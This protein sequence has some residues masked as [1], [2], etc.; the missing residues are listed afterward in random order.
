V[1]RIAQYKGLFQGILK[2]GVS[3]DSEQK[4][5]FV[6]G[7][8]ERAELFLEQILQV[9]NKEGFQKSVVEANTGMLIKSNPADPA[10]PIVTIP[11]SNVLA[12]TTLHK[13]GSGSKNSKAASG[14]K[15]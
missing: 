9:L 5:M 4:V 8:R 11:N 3:A 7:A 14:K 13:S 6:L 10:H 15:N 2:F 12:D 1:L